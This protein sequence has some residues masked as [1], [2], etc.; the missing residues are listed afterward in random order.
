VTIDRNPEL[1]G[2]LYR[3]GAFELD[4]G[5]Y[6][7]RRDGSDL[8]VQPK[9]LDLLL[10]LVARRDRVVPKEEI[11]EALWAGVA[12]TD[13]VLSRAIHAA[14]QAVGDDGGQQSVIQ[15]VRRRGF[16]FVADVDLSDSPQAAPEIATKKARPTRQGLAFVGRE[17]E[18]QRLEEALEDANQGHGRI[19]FVSSE[20]GGGKT[21]LLEEFSRRAAATN[22]PV[23]SG[24]CWEGEG[25]RPY[26][27]W[28]QI[29]RAL[30][31]SRSSETLREQMGS[32]A[33]DIARV[34]PSLRER[35]PELPESPAVQ[36]D[37]ERF[38]LFDSIT[39]FLRNVARDKG[40]QI[41]VLDDLQWADA[42]SLRLIE[43]LAHEMVGVPILLL[44]AYREEEVEHSLSETLGV[45]ARRSLF[46][47]VSLKGL[48]SSEIGQILRMNCDDEPSEE[49]ISAVCEKTDGNPF[50]VLEIAQLVKNQPG[51]FKTGVQGASTFSLPQGVTAVVQR[52]LA[53][54][55][56]KAH[57]V[58]A[59]AAVIGQEF[60]REVLVQVIESELKLEPLAQALNSSI[61]T[62]VPGSLGRYRFVHALVSEALY[63]EIETSDRARIH[64]RVAR[65]L[66]QMQGMSPA[67][68]LAEIAFH[69]T[70][71]AGPEDFEKA[72][73]FAK[74]AGEL[75]V[76]QFAWE[77]AST[78]FR[79]ALRMLERREAR[80]AHERCQLLLATAESERRA[81][82]LTSAREACTS[83]AGLARRFELPEILGR[84]AL[85]VQTPFDI[86][87]GSVDTV[88]VSLLEDALRL[89]TEPQSLTRAR[90]LSRLAIAKYWSDDS[91]LELAL[92]EEAIDIAR[93]SGD[94]SALAE[95]LFAQT[96][97][98]SRPSYANRKLD[99]ENEIARL[100][101]ESGDRHLIFLALVYRSEELLMRG[102]AQGVNRDL[103]ELERVAEE[104]RQPPERAFVRITRATRLLM[105]GRV[106]ESAEIG[107]EALDLGALGGDLSYQLTRTLHRYGIFYELLTLE[108][109]EDEVRHLA[110]TLRPGSMWFCALANLCSQ[111]GKEEEARNLFDSLASKNFAAVGPDFGWAASLHHL[112]ETCTRLRDSKSAAVLYDQLQ[113]HAGRFATFSWVVFHGPISRYL[114]LLA[115]TAG[116]DLEAMH[117]FEAA[118][119]SCQ[120]MDAGLWTARVQCDYAK[121]LLERNQP[122]DREKAREL[123]K[124]AAREAEKMDSP[125]L[126]SEID[127]ITTS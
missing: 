69:Y 42:P 96:Y 121:F 56:P 125:R 100:A 52:R 1:A 21:R 87:S 35:L 116:H 48:T 51:A 17:H 68:N 63:E 127:S 7:L 111:I 60:S 78:H 33:L 50:L 31:A 24:W 89:H 47:Q 113:S 40:T 73:V 86:L 6:V 53:M 43:F 30:I 84:A 109:L 91:E 22:L 5:L 71:G 124:R 76:G 37:Q 70:E 94:P 46:E 114:A 27:P 67:A 14:R 39:S 8:D 66:E 97:V 126:R 110:E 44:G 108:K 81:G 99:L 80:T 36:S 61:V 65:V 102:D 26:W 93:N 59:V 92:T 12:A 90:L 98:Y 101:Y 9:V 3:F 45:L 58:L 25:A 28:V 20:A 119:R 106:T 4:P 85:G 117:H 41:L 103:A 74:R 29:L 2:T 105:Q 115:A 83:A 16:R 13:D 34:I 18:L 64:R 95:A 38:R 10:Y 23:H 123:K 82:N 120:A 49:L 11:M 75:A 122:Q 15:T 77:E 72:I 57:R 54:L 19:V 118:I 62:E 104:L 112:A 107:R 79:D 55:P 32:S 88:E